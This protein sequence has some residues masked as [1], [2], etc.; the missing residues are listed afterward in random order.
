MNDLLLPMNELTFDELVE[1]GRSLIPTLAPAWTDHNVHDPGIMLIELLAWIAEAQM[2][3]TSRMR[4]D[5]RRAYAKLLG[6][7]AHGP[8]AAQGLIWPFAGSGVKNAPAPSW[9]AGRV[10][11]AA[12]LVTPD[13][14][15][16]PVF[17]TSSDVQ[18]TTARLV[19]V[20]THFASGLSHD[21]TRAN[22]Q[23]SATFMPLPS[24]LP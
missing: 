10:I 16:A 6:V 24:L 4:R 17:Y 19:R 7:E 14:P 11:P 21:W 9:S 8:Q 12:T 3:S 15:D 22:T 20:E 23:E 18:L 13:R 5:E 1:M 2:Y